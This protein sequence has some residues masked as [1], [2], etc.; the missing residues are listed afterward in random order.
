[1]LPGVVKP[2]D[3]SWA[4][5]PKP[6]AGIG[7]NLE[8]GQGPSLPDIPWSTPLAA[9][10]VESTP[11]SLNPEGGMERTLRAEIDRES[12]FTSRRNLIK[13]YRT[14]THYDPVQFMREQK[15]SLGVK[16]HIQKTN[17]WL[18]ECSTNHAACRTPLMSKLPTRV[19]DVSL[20]YRELLKLHESGGGEGQ[21]IA[22]SYCWGI[23][24]D[25]TT[26]L[27]T[28]E[29][30]EPI[31]LSKLPQTI[32]DAVTVTRRLNIRYLWVD[33]LCII[34]DS[35]V[36]KAVE[37]SAMGGFYKNAILTIAVTCAVGVQDGFLRTTPPDPSFWV[38]SVNDT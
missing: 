11:S 12:F 4:G 8:S 16:G 32:H 20:D 27:R 31:L 29:Y 26:A 22:L 28:I 13:T 30:D 36:D 24:Q 18:D 21:Y 2:V 38:P 1:M 15:F 23:K 6:F 9:I 25:Y 17:S 34:Q 10:K 37:I 35:P 33:A 7:Q 19:I 5:G 3:R 14:L